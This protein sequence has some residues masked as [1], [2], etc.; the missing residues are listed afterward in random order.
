MVRAHDGR[1]TGLLD[2]AQGAFFPGFSTAGA[3][4]IRGMQQWFL[5]RK[6]DADCVVMDKFKDPVG[7]EEDCPC[8]DEDY[9]WCVSS[10]P[11]LFARADDPCAQRLQLC[12]RW[13]R[14]HPRWTRAGPQ[15]RLRARERQVQG[16]E[17]VPPH[18]WQHVRRSQGHQEGR[19][20]HEAVSCWTGGAG[21]DLAPGGEF[22][23][24]R[25]VGSS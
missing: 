6:Q 24:R 7:V 16:I 10:P 19:T 13:R 25:R 8:S 4:L 14:V 21:D 5:R 22:C 3:E 1:L 2:G 23:V 9:E 15:W 18:S 20:D 17:R 11:R 12:P